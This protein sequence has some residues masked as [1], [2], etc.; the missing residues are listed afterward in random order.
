MAPTT[1]FD[2]MQAI[3][4]ADQFAAEGD[5]KYAKEQLNRV[6]GLVSEFGLNETEYSDQISAIR[7][8]ALDNGITIKIDA[9]KSWARCGASTQFQE[10]LDAL[11]GYTTELKDLTGRDH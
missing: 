6:Q 11:K 8:K 5:V 2:L 3:R 4:T 10:S 7:I 1:Q 9:V